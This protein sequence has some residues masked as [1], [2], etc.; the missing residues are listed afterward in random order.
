M[1][2]P[3][4]YLPD[5]GEGD[6]VHA[7]IGVEKYFFA[8]GDRILN[9]IKEQREH[10]DPARAHRP[11]RRRALLR[12]RQQRGR[13]LV[14]PWRRSHTASRRARTCMSI[15]RCRSQPRPAQQVI[16]L[17]EPDRLRHR[18]QDHGRR[19]EPQVGGSYVASVASPNPANPGAKRHSH[20]AAFCSARGRGGR[21]RRDTADGRRLPA[22]LRD[23]GQ[24]RGARVR[25]RQLRAA[26][27]CARV[28]AGRDAAR[29]AMTG[30]KR[31]P[32]PI[33]TTF[34]FVNEPSVIRYTTDGSKPNESSPSWDSTG[35]REPGE[36]FHLTT[37]TTFQWTARD[38]KGNTSTGIA[39]VHDQAVD[40]PAVRRPASRRAA[41]RD[42][43][44]MSHGLA[45]LGLAR[46]ARRREPSWSA[47]RLVG[48]A[49]T[50]RR[51]TA[52]ARDVRHAGAV[53]AGRVP[54]R[55]RLAPATRE[56]LAYGSRAAGATPGRRAGDRRRGLA[57]RA[58]SCSRTATGS[59]TR[60]GAVRAEAAT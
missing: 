9:R 59:C 48:R 23:R 35:P 6:A 12:R 55:R 40:L 20:A 58:G 56:F 33:T 13:A 47:A 27:V 46:S 18:R 30:P 8:A 15:R 1:W 53:P 34:V 26:G 25:R 43:A 2:A 37:T 28:R 41:R 44:A 5:R 54:R 3:G 17:A 42:A 57:P 51:P 32:A 7:N 49:R 45:L 16:R 10:G 21:G 31:R 19:A 14:Q 38:I 4:A 22:R 60:S 39:E 36:V 11:D 24:A 29:G 50:V 52:A